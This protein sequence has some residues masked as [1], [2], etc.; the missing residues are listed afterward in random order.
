MVS[1]VILAVLTVVMS[2][3]TVCTGTPFSMNFPV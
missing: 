3:V 2:G 1:I